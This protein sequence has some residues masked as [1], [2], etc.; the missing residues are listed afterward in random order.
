MSNDQCSKTLSSVAL[1][2]V[3]G[4]YLFKSEL[5]LH[6]GLGLLFLA[7][8]PNPLS[9]AIARAWLALSEILGLVNSKIIL[10]VIY[11]VVLVPVS[12]CYRK[13]NR[14]TVDYFAGRNVDSF[15]LAADRSYS[16][17]SFE[18]TW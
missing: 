5:L 9:R 11:C 2:L 7:V 18:K 6:L 14:K 3:I 8:F 17:D 16:P 15:F 1:V 13:L 4:R 12:F 10:T